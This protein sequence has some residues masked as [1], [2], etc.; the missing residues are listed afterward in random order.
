MIRTILVPLDGTPFAEHALPYAATLAKQSGAVLHLVT[1]STPLAETSVEST[2][3]SATEF[4][5]DLTAR[6]RT[7]LKS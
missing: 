6:Y 4:E 5:Q 1:V 3:F 7:Y 2:Y